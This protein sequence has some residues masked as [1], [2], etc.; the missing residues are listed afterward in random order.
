LREGLDETL[1][2]LRL[3]VTGA[4]R[5]T[6]ATTNPIENLNSLIGRYTRNVKRWR[7]GSMI[8][9]WVAAVLLDAET[10]FRRIR[11]CSDM[12]RLI[13]A[14]VKPANEVAKVA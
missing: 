5:R 12:P 4:L 6:L 1:T 9:R 13:D 7:H 8:E 3:H 11:G 2:V 10:R 14:L